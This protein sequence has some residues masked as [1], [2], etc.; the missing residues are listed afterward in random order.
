MNRWLVIA[1]LLGFYSTTP[2][3]ATPPD[4]IKAYCTRVHQSYQIRLVCVREED[5]AK[6]RLYRLE[7]MPYGIPPEIWTYCARVHSSWQIM[8]VCTRAEVAAKQQLSR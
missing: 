2:A 3:T 5:A 4:D 7:G 8:E 1:L 6:R